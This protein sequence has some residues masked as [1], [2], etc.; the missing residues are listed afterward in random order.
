VWLLG[1]VNYKKENYMRCPMRFNSAET[2][3]V[4]CLEEECAWWD[5]DFR[6][7]VIKRITYIPT[8]LHDLWE[9]FLKE[10]E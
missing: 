2:S 3:H 9:V 6:I 10:E 8:R 1:L 4:S 7:C 5:E